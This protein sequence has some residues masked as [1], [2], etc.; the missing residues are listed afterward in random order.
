MVIKMLVLLITFIFVLEC[1]VQ[2]F[3][4]FVG[5]IDLHEEY[6]VYGEHPEVLPS[7]DSCH[8]MI[9]EGWSWVTSLVLSPNSE[10]ADVGLGS[11]LKLT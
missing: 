1:S 5:T 2:C 11:G 7:Y 9:V 6:A 3:L 8:R 4:D 10:R